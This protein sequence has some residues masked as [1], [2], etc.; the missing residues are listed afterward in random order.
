MPSSVL[1]TFFNCFVTAGGGGGGVE[2]SSFLQEEKD[3]TAATAVASKNF[4]FMTFLGLFFFRF[5]V[6]ILPVLICSAM[7][8]PCTLVACCERNELRKAMYELSFASLLE[9][10]KLQGEFIDLPL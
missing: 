2:G 9:M 7:V 4:C 6:L 8:Q 3:S 10:R 5:S 1:V